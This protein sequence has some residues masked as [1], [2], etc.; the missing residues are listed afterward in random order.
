[1]IGSVIQE[2]RQRQQLSLGALALKAGVGK[3]TLSRWEAGKAR[4][5]AP[6]LARVLETLGVPEATQRQCFQW[7]GTRQAER[8]LSETSPDDSPVPISGGELLRA[9]RLRSGRTQAEAARAVGV[10]QALLSRWEHNDCWPDD[11]RLQQLCQVL[12]AT[13]YEKQDLATRAWQN[14]DELPRD[15]ERL[16]LALRQLEKQPHRFPKDLQY[17]ALAS[18]YHSLFKE[19]QIGDN[20]SLTVWGYFGNYLAWHSR[21]EEVLQV[22][23][24]LFNRFK[25]QFRPLKTHEMMALSGLT[26]S[27]GFLLSQRQALEILLGFEGRIRR[28]NLTMWYDELSQKAGNDGQ[29]DRACF[30]LEQGIQSATNEASEWYARLQYAERL[31][32]YGRPRDAM[33]QVEKCATPTTERRLSIHKDLVRGVALEQLGVRSEAISVYQRTREMLLQTPYPGLNN[34]SNDLQKTLYSEINLKI[35]FGH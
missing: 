20:E 35:D 30:Y 27:V 31:C 17:L 9:L 34:L 15:K 10:T 32:R 8:Y 26:D 33:A 16:D 28:G 7:L 22:T 13:S 12:R 14:H 5:Y 1:M 24:P 23:M 3:A 11:T 2:A 18:R 29:W 4:P 21:L 6:E 25:S 19:N